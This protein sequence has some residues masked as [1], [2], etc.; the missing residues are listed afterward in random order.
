[1]F[2]PESLSLYKQRLLA[3]LSALLGGLFAYFFV[4]RLQTIGILGNLKVKAG[5]GFGVFVLMLIWWLSPFSPV[6]VE[7]G[8]FRVRV[9]VIGSQG[10]PEDAGVRVWSTLGGEAKQVSGGWEIEIPTS[11]RPEDKKLT[12]YAEK[13]TQFMSGKI[14]VTLER[15]GDKQVTLVLERNRSGKVVGIVTDEFGKPLSGAKVTV[16]GSSASTVETD[17][18]GRFEVLPGIAPGEEVR[19]RVEKPGYRIVEQYHPSGDTPATVVLKKG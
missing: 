4:G 6:A 18:T 15:P 8:T 1:M 10:V 2:G 5:A 14:D 13:A 16:I 3:F 9:T 7:D 12:V 17:A 11:K 19:L